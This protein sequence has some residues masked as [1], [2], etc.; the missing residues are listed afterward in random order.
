M[1]RVFL[2]TIVLIS[3]VLFSSCTLCGVDGTEEGVFIK[4]PYIFGKGG[5]DQEALVSGS[6]WKV[7]STDFVTYPSIPIKYT[8]VFDDAFCDD[9]TPM[10]L[11]AHIT[12]QLKKGKAPVLHQNYG[13]K[14]YD[15]VVKESFREIVRNFISTYDMYTLTSNREVYDSINVEIARKLDIYFTSL[16]EIQEFPISI[17][18]IVVDRAKPNEEVMNELNNTARMAQAK[19][20]QLKQQEVEEQRKITEHKRALA[21]MEYRK[22]MGMTPAEFIQLRTLEIIQEKPN[23]NIDVLFGNA[24]TSMWDVKKK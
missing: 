17:V 23:A 5:V 3:T 18:R 24:G 11:S 13:F 4:K 20:T 12:L 8:E 22:T 19:Q 9:N 6:E 14:W 21:D 1:K 2:M 10:D 16:G 15:N 7:F